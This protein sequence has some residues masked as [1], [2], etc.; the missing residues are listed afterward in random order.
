M[1]VKEKQKSLQ[2]YILICLS[3]FV[4]LHIAWSTHWIYKQFGRV[5]YDEI[6]LVLDIGRQGIDNGLFWSFIRKVLLRAFGYALAAT[7]VCYFLKKYVKYIIPIVYGIISIFIIYIFCFSNIQTG[8]LFKNIIPTDFYEKEYIFPET[9]QIAF[10][11]KRNILVIALE[12]IEKIYA[13][14]KLFGKKGLIPNITKLEKDNVS[15]SR[16]DSI[17][18]LS[19]TIAAITGMTYGLPLFFTSYRNTEKMKGAYGIAS[20]FNKHGYDTYS[21]FPASGKFSLKE[22]FMKNCGFNEVIDGEA[23][24]ES[25]GYELEIEPFDGVDDKTLFDITKPKIEKV[26]SNKKPYFIFMETVNTHCEGYFLKSCEEMGFKQES[27]EDITRCADKI[28]HAFV[29]WFRKKDPTAVIV[30]L[31]DHNQHAGEIMDKLNEVADRPLSN[32]FIN[33]NVFDGAD[34]TRPVSAMDFFPTIIESA[35]GI[36]KDCRLG[37]GT[38]L[39]ARCSEYKTLR[40][41]YGDEALQ[42]LMESKNN[43]YYKLVTGK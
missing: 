12:S 6:M 37:L 29:D 39:S 31:D 17:A 11:E 30:L 5:N 8:T 21:W 7:A 19:H 40:E 27:M 16:Y 23:F 3:C 33:T 18:G 25:L 26:I 20:I 15:F 13:D 22:R 42:K 1:T 9:A 28:V 41:E 4:L 32:A 2:K 24:N 36:I 34:T 38:A 43:L 10:P 14:E 35:G